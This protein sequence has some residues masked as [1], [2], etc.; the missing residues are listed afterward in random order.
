MWVG[1]DHR[2]G[3]N[4]SRRRSL[5]FL[6]G[7]AGR[8]RRIGGVRVC[9]RHSPVDGWSLTVAVA[10]RLDKSAKSNPNPKPGE[11]LRH[12]KRVAGPVTIADSADRV[13]RRGQHRA[14]GVDEHRVGC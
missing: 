12:A 8:V 9:L 13:S 2:Y 7:S 6:N 14:D 4:N 5:A 11:R 10:Q 1:T 3:R